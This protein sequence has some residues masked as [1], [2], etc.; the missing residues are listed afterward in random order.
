LTQNLTNYLRR[1]LN[2]ALSVSILLLFF[3][4]SCQ[5]NHHDRSNSQQLYS[6]KKF[7]DGD[8]FWVNDGS[9]KGLK[10]RLIGINSPEPRAYFGREKEPYGKA[11]STHMIKLVGNSKV[12]LEFDVDSLDRY[13]RTL[14]YVFLE[15][16]TFI[17]KKM[18]EDG[19]AQVATYPPNVKYVDTFLKAQ[20]KVRKKER[21]LWAGGDVE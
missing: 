10:L 21:G 14:A 13:G 1:N 7:V 12:R 15:D 17:N 2:L 8:T 9:E 11:A 3:L 16:G 19:Y 18:I 5:S 20:R 6:I 4:A